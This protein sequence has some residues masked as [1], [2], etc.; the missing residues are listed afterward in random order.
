MDVK[1]FAVMTKPN[2]EVQAS[3]YLKRQGYHTFAPFIRKR[4]YLGRLRAMQ[5]VDHAL[6][7]RYVFVAFTKPTHN[8][9]DVNETYGVSTVVRLGEE[10]LEIPNAV[11]DGLMSLAEE[12]PIGDEGETR[13]IV[14]PVRLKRHIAQQQHRVFDADPGASLKLKDEAP[15]YGLIVTLASVANLDKT[16][17]IAVFAQ[18]LGS[19]R[20]MSLPVEAVAKVLAT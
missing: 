20:E 12:V 19:E 15:Y 8:H 16:G 1:W 5:D 18:M 13:L 10:P 7:P 9:H 6:F 4:R 17:E 2:A 3:T 11:M 14:D